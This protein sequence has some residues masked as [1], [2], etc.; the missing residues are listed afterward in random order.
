MRTV[1]AAI[2]IFKG[3]L[4]SLPAG[5]AVREAGVC[6]NLSDTAAQVFRLLALKRYPR[7]HFPLVQ[8]A[9]L[10]GPHC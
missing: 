7:K 9:G 10:N 4:S 3:S 1:V 2:D 5:E 6:R 8:T